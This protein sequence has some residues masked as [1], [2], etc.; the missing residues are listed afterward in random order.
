MEASEICNNLTWKKKSCT[1]VDR[2]NSQRY[3]LC[4]EYQQW[5]KGKADNCYVSAE[6]P[7][8]FIYY[9]TKNENDKTGMLMRS[10]RI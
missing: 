4:E 7:S 6:F 9:K 3:L 1:V 2:E 8:I 10:F 5:Q